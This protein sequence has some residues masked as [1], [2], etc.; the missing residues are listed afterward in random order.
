MSMTFGDGVND[1]YTNR[2]YQAWDHSLTLDFSG[3]V[4]YTLSGQGSSES[5]VELFASLYSQ[6]AAIY[7]P[8]E[9][10]ANFF[11]SGFRMSKGDSTQN[12]NFFNGRSNDEDSLIV[13]DDVYF[14]SITINNRDFIYDY[15]AN[16]P[17]VY[18]QNL[19]VFINCTIED[20]DSDSYVFVN[21]RYGGGISLFDVIWDSSGIWSGSFYMSR[22][23]AWRL[24]NESWYAL[25]TY[26]GLSLSDEI[27]NSLGEH[28]YIKNVIIKDSSTPN[29]FIYDDEPR[30]NTTWHFENV[31]L[32]NTGGYYWFYVDGDSQGFELNF[33]VQNVTIDD[34]STLSLF[35]FLRF[36][37]D[38]S[39]DNIVITDTSYCD[40]FLY[41]W[42]VS[43][44][45]AMNNITAK[46]SAIGRLTR[47]TDA[48]PYLNVSNVYFENSEL[49]Y[50]LVYAE[51]SKSF[52]MHNIHMVDVQ[53]WWGLFGINSPYAEIKNVS[54]RSSG[55]LDF[56]LSFIS[57]VF[58]TDNDHVGSI[59]VENIIAEDTIISIQLYTQ[60]GFK[61][62]YVSGITCSNC[63]TNNFWVFLEFFHV[64][65]WNNEVH[66]IY[67]DGY[68]KKNNMSSIQ[69]SLNNCTGYNCRYWA[70]GIFYIYYDAIGEGSAYDLDY[71]QTNCDEEYLDY[72]YD[73]T[74]IDN[75]VNGPIV[76]IDIESNDCDMI[77]DNWNV[78]ENTNLVNASGWNGNN[79]DT[80]WRE[81]VYMIV[82][83]LL[84]FCFV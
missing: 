41:G 28:L 56:D 78:K 31:Q 30:T 61:E 1:T 63:H 29:T 23:E 40:V 11:L 21:Q 67:F 26:G 83:C 19:F 6:G 9:G 84:S 3:R 50:A 47:V 80:R 33:I 74:L 65:K 49:D 51:S 42:R 22:R 73:V 57:G 4:H 20:Y 59:Q 34:L 48:S 18:G 46:N 13:F 62:S 36:D 69:Y 8:Q 70:Q 2:T 37:G 25:E 68:Y 15:G 43:G 5:D 44:S 32:I 35:H 16:G 79:I 81:G 64:E 24:D 77:F 58:V 39:F 52:V 53:G 27:K 45:I 60:Y 10:G 14:D 54:L 82:F 7:Y 12:R 71:N 76:M 55:G 17:G 72:Y 66:D 75:A 38:I